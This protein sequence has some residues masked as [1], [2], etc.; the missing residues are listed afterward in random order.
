MGVCSKRKSFIFIACCMP[1]PMHMYINTQ[2]VF[3][4]LGYV[5]MHIGLYSVNQLGTKVAQVKEEKEGV[6]YTRVFLGIPGHKR[7]GTW[8]RAIFWT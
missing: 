4:F 2:K 8:E 5:N 6:C 1:V 7:A 3:I